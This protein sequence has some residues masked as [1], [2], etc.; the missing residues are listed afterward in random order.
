MSWARAAVACVLAA[1]CASEPPASPVVVAAAGASDTAAA[2]G[3]AVDAP[4]YGPDVASLKLKRSIVVRFA[5]DVDAKAVGTVAADTRVGWTRAAAGPGCD[6]WIE[7]QP[8][9]WICDQYLEPS[10]EPPAGVELPRLQEGEIVPGVYGK[11]VG[12]GVTVRKVAD[13]VVGGRSYWKTLDGQKL[14]A[15]RIRQHEP[16]RFSGAWIDSLRVPFAWAQSR[17]KLGDAVR[18]RSAPDAKAAVVEELAPRTLVPIEDL[19]P[20]WTRVAEGRFI[21]TAD[22]HV[23]RASEPPPDVRGEGERWLDVD[24]DE[25]VVV[26]HEGHRPVFA[27]LV[28]TGNKKWPTPSGIYRIWLKFS[29]TTMN[30]QMGDEQP[31]S[32]ATVPWTMFFAKDLAFHTAYWHDRFGEARSHGCVNVSPI[33]ARTLYEWASP[34]VPAGWTMSHGL[35]ERPGS[36][37]KIHATAAPA[38]EYRGY[39][40]RVHDDL[41]SAAVP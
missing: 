17:S 32:V 23:A 6:R 28:S 13:L 37:V 29:E 19:G 24:L 36:L 14:P 27:T 3:P 33:D 4:P 18:V 26:A 12:T 38:V 8:R 16:S 11:V 15:S 7:I 22:L 41:A 1:A 31:Y 9:G 40:K 34:D 25:Q 39:A 35:F 10:R 2:P 21:A 20:E 30:G 5:P